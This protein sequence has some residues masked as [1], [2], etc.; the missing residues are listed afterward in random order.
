MKSGAQ[1]MIDVLDEIRHE[2]NDN[3]C[4]MGDVAMRAMAVALRTLYR[5]KVPRRYSREQAARTLGIS[6]RQ[7]S[8]VVSKME[9]TTRRDGFRNV[10]FTE[11]DIQR[12]RSK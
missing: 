6:T 2:V 11:E 9:I 4:G 5:S 7:L 10:Y 1:E 3:P 12:M 8:R